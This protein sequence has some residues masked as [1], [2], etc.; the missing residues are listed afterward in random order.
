M[1]SKSQYTANVLKAIGHPIRV[2]IIRKIYEHQIL[3]VGAIQDL[4]N[5]PQPVISL[6]LA[7][8]K[9]IGIIKSNKEGKKSFYF[10]KNNS[11]TQVIEI[12]YYDSNK[13]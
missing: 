3:S 6:H 11:V 7:I 5:I 10:I 8:L 13:I 4:L 9:K 2:D 1:S 12:L